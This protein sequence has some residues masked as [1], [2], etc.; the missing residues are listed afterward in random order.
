MVISAISQTEDLLLYISRNIFSDTIDLSY[1]VK[2]SGINVL[3]QIVSSSQDLQNLFLTYTDS[4]TN[5][6]LI[7]KKIVMIASHHNESKVL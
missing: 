5:E 2:I 3:S 7:I 6:T 4:D 1:D